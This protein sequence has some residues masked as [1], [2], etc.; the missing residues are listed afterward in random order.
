MWPDDATLGSTQFY[1]G[2]LLGLRH[3]SRPLPCPPTHHELRIH[4]D[5]E[6]IIPLTRLREPRERGIR[7][8][9]A[10]LAHDGPKLAGIQCGAQARAPMI[11]VQ[12]RVGVMICAAREAGGR[13]PRRRG[14][15]PMDRPQ[16]GS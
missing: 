4:E 11:G 8:G 12:A 9:V 1:G 7:V 2:V 16:G 3:R 15:G 5:L 14:R 13:G 6:A 10:G